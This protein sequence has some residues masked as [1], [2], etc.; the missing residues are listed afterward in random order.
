MATV[1]RLGRVVAELLRKSLRSPCG[2]M[3]RTGT[4]KVVMVKESE[5]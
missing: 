1:C 2:G 3:L 5:Q 4:K